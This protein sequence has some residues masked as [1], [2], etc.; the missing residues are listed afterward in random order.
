MPLRNT[1]QTVLLRQKKVKKSAGLS[2]TGLPKIMTA[3]EAEVMEIPTV[4]PEREAIILL[5]D[6][7]EKAIP[8][9]S[10]T[11]EV[12][13]RLQ[14][15]TTEQEAIPPLEVSTEAVVAAPPEVSIGEVLP[16]VPVEVAGAAVRPGAEEETKLND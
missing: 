12:T 7:P 2:L 9:L 3:E 15:A 16:A 6:L 4:L 1:V 10:T 5:P 13:G 11:P 8:G 14:E